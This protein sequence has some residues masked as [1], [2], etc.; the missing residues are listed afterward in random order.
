MRPLK[1]IRECP[2]YG[3]EN[4]AYNLDAARWISERLY[5]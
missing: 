4:N 5:K 3:G 1:S 2:Q